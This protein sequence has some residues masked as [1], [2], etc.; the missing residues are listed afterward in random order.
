M[1]VSEQ[2]FVEVDIRTAKRLGDLKQML[3]VEFQATG[4]MESNFCEV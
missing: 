3:T 4:H 1:A 2:R